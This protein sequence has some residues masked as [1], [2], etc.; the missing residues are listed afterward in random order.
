MPSSINTVYFVD[1]RFVDYVGNP[2][3]LETV[4]LAGSAG[5]TG[6]MG[7]AGSVSSGGT[8]LTMYQARKYVKEFWPNGESI[9][10]IPRS[11][12]LNATQMDSSGILPEPPFDGFALPYGDYFG[13]TSP[14]PISTSYSISDVMVSLWGIADGST[15][16]I[17]LP[18]EQTKIDGPPAGITNKVTIDSSSGDII[19]DYKYPGGF[20]NR[21]RAV[22]II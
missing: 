16:W 10:T 14:G 18:V 1:G 15:G 9:L 17:S 22:I 11:E 5:P 6:P 8:S 21:I 2:I 7:P 3:P 13:P 20:L 19:I 12:I 4:G